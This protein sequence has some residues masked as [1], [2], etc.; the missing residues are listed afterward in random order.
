M[1]D[2]DDYFDDDDFVL[3]EAAEAALAATER[4][5]ATQTQQQV[6]DRPVLKRQRI[7]TSGWT[8]GLGTRCSDSYDDFGLYPEITVQGNGYQAL[9]LNEPVLAAVPPRVPAHN[10]PRPNPPQ[11]QPQQ[12][13]PVPQLPQRPI[14]PNY[15]P[16]SVSRVPS[17]SQAPSRRP[18]PAPGPHPLEAQLQQVLQQ[19]EEVSLSVVC[20]IHRLIIAA[21]TDDVRDTSKIPRS[22]RNQNQE[23]RGSIHPTEDNREGAWL[24]S[25]LK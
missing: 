7:S 6:V 19:V 8:P 1:A 12:N 17:A 4:Q 24:R 13:V 25:T 23:R 5:Y 14:T 21:K 2:F 18:S 9:A 16:Q 22:P 20:E 3:D 15:R 10:P 11:R